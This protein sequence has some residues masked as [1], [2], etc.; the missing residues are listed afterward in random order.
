MELVPPPVLSLHDHAVLALLV[1]RPRHGFA[2]AR[3]LGDDGPLGR[4]W[5]VR[6][7]QVYRSLARLEDLSL[8]RPDRGEPGDGGPTRT[9]MAPTP[10]GDREA[11][12][13]LAAPVDHV[14]D[15]R[16]E[17]L[18]KI[19]LSRRLG[20]DPA[21]LLAAQAARFQPVRAS[22]AADLEQATGEDRLVA[23]WRAEASAA[24]GRFLD[25]AHEIV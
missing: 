8:A 11:R 5:R 6:R 2:L 13:W 4:V 14:R 12:R 9:I 3:E 20:I 18:L 22:L 19:V 15:V 16:T 1:E 7:P 24:V 25:R 21:P 10:A 17:L 23:L